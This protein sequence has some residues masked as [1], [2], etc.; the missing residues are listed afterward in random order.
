V[1][2]DVTDQLLIRSFASVRYCR[3]N[4]STIDSTITI[5]GL[6][7]SLW[8]SW[9]DCCYGS[10]MVFVLMNVV[11]V[12][13]VV[14]LVILSCLYDFRLFTLNLILISDLSY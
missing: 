11:V 1:G 9:W 6:Q 5:H 7:E 12:V 14:V 13:V 10:S 2:F 3:K 8:H 4:C